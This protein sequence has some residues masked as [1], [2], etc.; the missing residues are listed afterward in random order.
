M[1]EFIAAELGYIEDSGVVI[2]GAAASR[3]DGDEYHYINFQRPV[4][5]GGPDDEGIYFEC[6]GEANGGFN[7]VTS[8]ELTH[9]TLTIRLAAPEDEAHDVIVV[10]FDKI[11]TEGLGSIVEGLYRIFTGQQERLNI[12][13]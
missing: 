5:T 1:I 9:G 13:A 12:I 11:A 7:I 3:D 6:D 10:R 2:C 8:C 4:E